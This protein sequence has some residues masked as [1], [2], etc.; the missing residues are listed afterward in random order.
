MATI[1]GRKRKRI[2]RSA[3]LRTLEEGAAEILQGGR[4]TVEAGSSPYL[5]PSRSTDGYREV[6]HE[7]DRRTCDCPYYRVHA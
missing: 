6:R 4:Q 2:R 7:K 1:C 3:T 5:V